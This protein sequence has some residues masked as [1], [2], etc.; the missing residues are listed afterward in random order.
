MASFS[1]TCEVKHARKPVFNGA[2][3][4]MRLT[5]CNDTSVDSFHCRFVFR[6]SK[7]MLFLKVKADVIR[8]V[9]LLN[10][11]I[12]MSPSQTRKETRTFKKLDL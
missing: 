7:K 12:F 2:V 3:L 11:E 10:P 8:C 5:A 4:R 6:I 1:R 9:F